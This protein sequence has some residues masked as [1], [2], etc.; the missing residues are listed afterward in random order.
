M[1]SAYDSEYKL[2]RF[3]ITAML[4]MSGVLSGI[5]ELL[6]AGFISV[7]L[8]SLPS[9]QLPAVKLIC[10][11][12]ALL[13]FILSLTIRAGIRSI[14]REPFP[15]ILVFWVRR[16]HRSQR[17]S[18]IALLIPP[19]ALAEAVIVLGFVLFFLSGGDR[20]PFYISIVVSL[21]LF[22]L[23]Y[24]SDQEKDKLIALDKFVKESEARSANESS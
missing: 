23:N 9:E 17:S 7:E 2:C 5:A 3:V 13:L 24:P 22:L 18:A 11:I 4:I 6:S 16:L 8:Q 10:A 15:P 21:P 20:M 12:L 1:S 19:V 14:D